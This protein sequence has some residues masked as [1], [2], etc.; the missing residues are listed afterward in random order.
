MR[1]SAAEAPKRVAALA[2]VLA[3]AGCAL[4][5]PTPPPP[6]ALR[7]IAFNDFHGHLK[8]PPG[9][10]VDPVK[11]TPTAAG[12]VA[13]LATAVGE[14]RRDAAHALVVAAGDL[15]GATPLVSSLLDDEPAVEA[16]NAIGLTLSAM[17]NHELDRGPAELLRLQR[18]GCHPQ[19]GCR[20][21]APFAGARFEWLAAN[22]V[23]QAS[24]RTLLPPYAIRHVDGVPVAFIGLTLKDTPRMVVVSATAGLRFDDEA[25]TVNA[26]VPE[27][28]R[29]GV[30]AI[31]VLMH[32]GGVTSG[33]GINGCDGLSG[34]LAGIVARM[35]PA[36]DVVVSAH[37]HRAYNCRIDG[38]LVTSAGSF[39][40]LLTRIDLTIDRRTRDVSAAAAENIVVAHDRF[41]PAPQL[42]ALVETYERITAPIAQRPIG[43]LAAPLP[44]RPDDHGE[45]AMGKLIAD[46][47]LA[48]TH[49]AGA[50]LALMNTGGVRAG[51]G[52]QRLDVSYEDLF[53]VQPFHNALVTLTLSGA[54]LQ[55]LLEQQWA[56][57]RHR[58]LLPSA[59]FGWRWRQQPDAAGRRIV[60]GSVTLHGRVVAD[61]DVVRL[62]VNS[63]MA[64]G[65]DGFSVLREGLDR[66][67]GAVDIEA[68]EAYVKARP[69]LAPD[70]LPRVQRVDP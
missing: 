34:P 14:L 40:T 70:P 43:R 23:L 57:G 41:A 31:V 20:G 33:G 63:F 3:L 32:E 62:T 30:E 12:G 29:Q 13:A 7:L 25:D 50:Q 37:T 56:S 54:Q 46:A 22:T 6:L 35:D 66:H 2:A 26:L 51:L 58:A 5:P 49:T 55:R 9:G 11:R 39:G 52:L 15:V 27:L 68:L 21:P 53:T 38:R 65:G 69:G 1:W 17:G 18:G 16:L 45:H 44:A 42:A 10:F 64:E 61:D 28:R 4:R 48:A 8:P 47:Q 36:V 59:G 60:A 67:V 24:G 19:K